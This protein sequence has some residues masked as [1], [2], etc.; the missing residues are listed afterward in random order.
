[1]SR[2]AEACEY[3]DWCIWTALIHIIQADVSGIGD[4]PSSIS[5]RLMSVTLSPSRHLPARGGPW[6][7]GQPAALRPRQH[8][9]AGRLC[10]GDAPRPC[11]VR[12]G[13]LL[14]VGAG[15]QSPHGPAHRPET[16]A[17]CRSCRAGP[18]MLP[19]PATPANKACACHT[20]R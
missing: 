20:L 2:R 14:R 6:N 5:F 4:I 15:L 11:S 9:R 1:M 3:R 18:T 12:G 8:A 16:G 13:R 10:T 19:T 17:C 7:G